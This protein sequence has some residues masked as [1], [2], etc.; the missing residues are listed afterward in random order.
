MPPRSS[1]LIALALY[2]GLLVGV[3]VLLL[4]LLTALLRC[5]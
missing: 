4:R 1:Y 2:A 5:L 3:L